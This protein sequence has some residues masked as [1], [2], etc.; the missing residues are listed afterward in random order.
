MIKKNDI[1]IR[2]LQKNDITE[3]Y[4]S[5]FK[6]DLVTKFLDARNLSKKEVLN[7]IYNG[8][9][10][11][12][13]YIYAICLKHNH[14]HIGNIKIG[15]IKRKDGISD[16]VTVV[17]D[18]SYWG[19][20]IASL[21]IM[22]AVNIGF[23]QGGIR[24]FSASINSLNSASVKAYTR[25]GLKVEAIIKNYFYNKIDNKIIFSDKVFVGCENKNYNMVIIK[26]WSPFL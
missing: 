11:G 12:S 8:Q 17:G 18:N 25:A 3:R 4:L 10:T 15:P 13:Y 2:L 22:H 5:W 23:N 6:D 9:E 1:Y 21:A 20:G 19:K 16:L 7:Y 14:L 26:D 24:K